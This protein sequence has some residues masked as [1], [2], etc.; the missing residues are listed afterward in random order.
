MARFDIESESWHSEGPAAAAPEEDDGINA[1]DDGI[2]ERSADRKPQWPKA[3]CGAATVMAADG[4]GVILIG[5]F[6]GDAQ[7]DS[8]ND[9]LREMVATQSSIDDDEHPDGKGVVC[10]VMSLLIALLLLRH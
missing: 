7:I 9:R 5:G 6:G 10:F 8:R 2:K 1:T 4:H 3:R